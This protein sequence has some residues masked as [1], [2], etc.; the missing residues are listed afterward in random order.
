MRHFPT[1]LAPFLLAVA[2]ACAL[3]AGPV[4]AACG[5]PRHFDS[6]YLYAGPY[7]AWPDLGTFWALGA[8]SPVDGNG[9][10]NGAY[11]ASD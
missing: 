7:V 9:I 5:A 8:G 10:D 11:P 1:R 6:T 2:V 3:H 4:E